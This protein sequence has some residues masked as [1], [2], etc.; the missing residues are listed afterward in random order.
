[1]VAN[2]NFN[3]NSLT[4]D[5]A[6]GSTNAGD[7]RGAQVLMSLNDFATSIDLGTRN[8]TDPTS[9]ADVYEHF[10][11]SLLNTPV[12]SGQTVSFR[13]LPFVST[14]NAGGVRF[15]NISVFEG[16]G[17]DLPGDVNGDNEVDGVDFA[18]LKMN[19]G[20]TGVNRGDGDLTLDGNVDFDDFRQW[21]SHATG[22]GA[23][24]SLEG[25]PEPTIASLLLI[26]LSGLSL[27][28]FGA[29]RRR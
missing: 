23:S 7:L 5:L 9:A 20:N 4:F 11:L 18:I 16:L 14:G 24:S 17:A 13:F 19:F 8:V 28:R 3:L 25:V 27:I 1:M 21:K 12:T 6:E 26:E 10:S 29:A 15:D 2:A 22:A